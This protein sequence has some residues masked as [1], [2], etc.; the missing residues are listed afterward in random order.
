MTHAT[1]ESNAIFRYAHGAVAGP[2]IIKLVSAVLAATLVFL[3][4]CAVGPNFKRPVTTV[5]PQWTVESTTGTSTGE[6][7]EEWW[8]SFNDP[9]FDKLVHQAIRANLDLQLAAARVDEARAA[10]GI[11]KSGLFPTV[12]ATVSASRNRQRVVAPVGA[13][14][15]SAKIVP[16]EFS[17]FQGGF[18]AS[19]EVDV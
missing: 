6:P 13:Q 12:D 14:G 3:T 4:G 5:S 15:S 16:I 17:N 19:W 9:E 1:N 11:A 18:D 7:A 8:K 10:R 2:T